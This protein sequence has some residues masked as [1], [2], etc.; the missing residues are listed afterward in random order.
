M[1]FQLLKVAD[2]CPSL[3][4]VL[5]YVSKTE[6]GHFETTHV[7]ELRFWGYT[8][9]KKICFRQTCKQETRHRPVA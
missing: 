8:K 4:K 3:L 2:L 6:V 7:E 1:A 5:N 9:N